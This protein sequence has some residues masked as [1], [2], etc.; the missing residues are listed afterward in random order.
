MAIKSR[1]Q[2]PTLDPAPAASPE[3]S[4][5]CMMTLRPGADAVEAMTLEVELPGG[6]GDLVIEEVEPAEELERMSS[7]G[8]LPQPLSS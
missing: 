7:N 8:S 2:G 5:S 4:L 6:G 1:S 3:A